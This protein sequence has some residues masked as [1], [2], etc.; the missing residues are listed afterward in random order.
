[1]EFVTKNAEET[2]KLGREMAIRLGS[3]MMVDG[4]KGATILALSGDLGSGKTT[5]VQG[6]AEGLGIKHGII[7]PTFILLREYKVQSTK[8]KVKNLYH[9]DLYRLEQ[10]VEQEVKNL[11]LEEIWEDPESIVVVEWAEK[12][13]DAIPKNAV[14]ISFEN[15][16]P[17]SRKIT[18]ND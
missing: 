3:G 15:L 14:W 1:M 8:Y 5:F 11:G 18:R 12:I 13:R 9:L 10:N 16:S 2:K 7:S 17:N 4:K 6:F